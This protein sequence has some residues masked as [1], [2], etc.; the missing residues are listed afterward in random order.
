MPHGNFDRPPETLR[1]SGSGE[2]VEA[3]GPLDWDGDDQPAK[4][5]TI[6]HVHIQQGN[7]HA[8][9]NANSLIARG[10]SEW[11]VDNVP[12]AGS[13][14]FQDGSADAAAKVEV[15]LEDGQVIREH[16]RETVELR[17]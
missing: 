15:V 17:Q 9:E 5:I 7:V 3:C 8:A 16:W 2:S 11:M 12:A 6:E 10:Q 4:T 14:R 1:R 13:G